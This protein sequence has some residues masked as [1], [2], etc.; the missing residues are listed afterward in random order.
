MMQ[1]ILGQEHAVSKLVT[2][3]K[4][5]RLPHA[6]LF[7]G[8]PGVGRKKTALALAQ[9]LLCETSP[10]NKK[11][12]SRGEKTKKGSGQ[13][14]RSGCGQC[15]VCKSVEEQNCPYMLVITPVSS[16]IKIG[17]VRQILEFLSLQSFSRARIILIDQAHLMNKQA[18]NC[19]LKVLE[20][21][22]QKVYFIL[23]TDQA[24]SLTPSL[25]SRMQSLRFL[26][27]S[28]QILSKIFTNKNNKLNKKSY[29]TTQDPGTPAWLFRS[30]HGSLDHLERNQSYVELRD[31]GFDMLKK[32]LLDKNLP[33][34]VDLVDSVKDKEQAEF[35]CLC[36]RQLV[37]DSLAEGLVPGE[38]L[39]HEDQK[40]L[41]RKLKSF[42]MDQLYELFDGLLQ[43]EMDLKRNI[44]PQL[45]FD[46][47]SLPFVNEHP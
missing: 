8:P 14:V 30:T 20:E 39:I 41:I 28:H 33:R 46:R 18:Q 43:M 21:P 38:E 22:P 36:W 2:A 42:S 37:R 23:I 24:H 31:K 17:E 13:V 19:L 35:I 5:N 7:T 45:G 16:W 10:V 34:V 44:D 9:T 12:A 40:E 1:D 29:V 27:L 3:V 32:I 11:Y 4:L 25:R 26:P 15:P 47:L 6:L